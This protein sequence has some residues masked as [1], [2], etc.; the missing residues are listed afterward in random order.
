MDYLR[1]A[2]KTSMYSFDPVS[3]L[4]VAFPVVWFVCPEGSTPLGIHHQYASANWTK[5]VE[6]SDQVGE[7]LT[8]PRPWSNGQT[9]TG[10]DGRRHCGA[11]RLWVG[12]LERLPSPLW[13]GSPPL[14]PCCFGPSGSG[15]GTA[16]HGPARPLLTV[17]AA[18]GAGLY[19]HSNWS[20]QVVLHDSASWVSAVAPDTW[21]L[22]EE[23][24]VLHLFHLS[25]KEGVWA[26]YIEPEGWHDWARDQPW[27]LR[28]FVPQAEIGP[29]RGTPDDN[30][31]A[32]LVFVR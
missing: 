9:P 6:Y 17:S 5:P 19:R 30:P 2:Y 20:G 21:T 4:E 13:A 3:G 7:V 23:D 1:S 24:G 18:H 27:R 10:L 16:E 11:D 8:A 15:V 28:G 14:P 32:P 31:S 29:P 26:E 25:S 22:Y 12:R